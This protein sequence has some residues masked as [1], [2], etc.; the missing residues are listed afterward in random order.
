MMRKLFE[1]KLRKPLQTTVLIIK[2]VCTFHYFPCFPCLIKTPNNLHI[3]I[4]VEM[5]AGCLF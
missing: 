1:E 2:V 4:G 5:G 3:K